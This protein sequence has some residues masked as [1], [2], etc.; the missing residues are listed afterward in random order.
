MT[1]STEPSETIQNTSTV[2]TPTDVVETDTAEKPVNG[3]DEEAS[4]SENKAG[5]R[6]RS[7][8]KGIEID[9]TSN[10]ISNGRPKRAL[11]KRK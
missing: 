9:E 10:N 5:K 6:K 2:D 8:K 11:P 3:V 1:S 4:A 7:T